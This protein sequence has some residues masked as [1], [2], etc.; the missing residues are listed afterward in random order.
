MQI[1]VEADAA[2]WTD[3]GAETATG[4]GIGA[5]SV[6]QAWG[7]DD[8]IKRTLLEAT[9]AAITG[10]VINGGY[11][12]AAGVTRTGRYAEQGRQLLGQGRAA[13][14]ATRWPGLAID[15]GLRRLGAT[16][17]ATLATL[18]I[19][20]QGVDLIDQRIAFDP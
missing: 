11:Q 6:Q 14:W 4:T 1:R 13:G 10:T 20:Q 17:E 15:H 12:G 9:P 8:G 18:A 2:V 5:D 7:S 3:V 16:G 19:G